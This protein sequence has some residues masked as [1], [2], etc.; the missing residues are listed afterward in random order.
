M[1]PFC[2]LTHSTRIESPT[3]YLWSQL[4]I[5]MWFFD[6]KPWRC[7]LTKSFWKWLFDEG[8]FFCGTSFIWWR[9]PYMPLWLWA[10]T[11]QP[12]R[13]L[14][15]YKFEPYM[16]LFD[17]K[18][19]RCFFNFEPIRTSLIASLEYDF[20]T[21]SLKVIVKETLLLLAPMLLFECKP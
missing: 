8:L 16:V 3:S 7:Y 5:K 11:Q 1:S 17:S 15:I 21:T 2:R 19:R 13:C 4:S 20:W 12:S 6:C 14:F 18:P 10:L 9:T